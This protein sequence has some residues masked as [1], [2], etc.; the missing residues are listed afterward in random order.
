MC[1]NKLLLPGWLDGSLGFHTGTV[2]QS[3]PVYRCEA[4]TD[5]KRY[6]SGTPI[7]LV[8]IV[9]PCFVF[10]NEMTIQTFPVF[11]FITPRNAEFV[12]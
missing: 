11:T 2:T 4:E 12:L 10:R 6:A 7:N 5:W 1:I 8:G 3:N 9:K